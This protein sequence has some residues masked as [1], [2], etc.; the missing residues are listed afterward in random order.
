MQYVDEFRNPDV[1]R[2]LAS[3][4]TELSS[5]L[6]QDRNRPLQIMEFCG[7][8]THTIFRFGLQQLLP[9]HIQLVHGPGCPVCVLPRGCIDVAIQLANQANVIFTTFGDAM[10]VPGSQQS[11]LQAKAAGADIRMVYSPLDALAL[12]RANPDREVIFFALGFETTM[13]STALTVLEASR[14]GIDNFSLFCHHITTVPTMT[15][16][17][18]DPDMRLDGFIAPGHVSMVV[19][20]K[21][22]EFVGAEFKKPLVITGFEPLDILQSIWMLLKQLSEGRSEVE[23][24]YTRVVSAKGNPAGLAAMS[25]VF[26][27][28][29]RSAW[30]GIGDIEQS[31][32]QLTDAYKHFD[33]EYKFSPDHA[34]VEDPTACHCGDVLK[35]AMQPWQCPLFGNECQPKHPLGAL[36]VSSEGACAAYY[37]YADINALKDKQPAQRITL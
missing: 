35:G 21:P 16:I 6:M 27:P 29:E 32:V 13:P 14:E 24:Q 26:E 10:R 8:H 28:R 25:D 4:I 11:L 20:D 36:M 33:A 7:G 15:A 12:A 3:E 18:Q 22:F 1:A 2:K 19:G 23:N 37:R 9:Q 34:M 17:L 30:R 5:M 31:G